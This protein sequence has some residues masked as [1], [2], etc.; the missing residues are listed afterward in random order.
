[1]GDSSVL[2]DTRHAE[3]ERE[4]G[5][6]LGGARVRLP[7]RFALQ[8]RPAYTPVLAICCRRRRIM[9]TFIMLT[10]YPL[11]IS[12]LNAPFYHSAHCKPSTTPTLRL[13]FAFA[14][15]PCCLGVRKWLFGC[16]GT[17]RSLSSTATSIY[18]IIRLALSPASSL[19]FRISSFTR[20]TV[21]RTNRTRHSHLDTTQ[22]YNTAHRRASFFGRQSPFD[23]PLVPVTSLLV[24]AD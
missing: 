23:P 15:W 13:P 8:S 2:G 17:K 9:T 7:S 6:S 10:P 21:T 20:S 12:T 22:H 11:F 16:V 19:C 5:G 14:L 3:G 24:F 1:M 18:L 4:E